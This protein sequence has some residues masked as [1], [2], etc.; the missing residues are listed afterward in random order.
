MTHSLKTY[1]F[2]QN[3]TEAGGEIYLVGGGVRDQ[4]LGRQTKDIDIIIRLIPIPDLKKILKKCGHFNQVGKAFGVIKF[5]PNE[6]RELEID[7]ALPRTEISTGTGHKDFLVQSDPSLEISQ[8]LKRRDF[9]INA[10]AINLETDEIIDLSNGKKDLKNKLIRT[11]FENSFVEDPLRMLRAIQFAARFD[12]NIAPETLEEMKTH[13][14]LISTVS[15][16]RIIIEINKLFD[17]VKP[18]VGFGLMRETKLLPL[19]FPDIDK[20][21]GVSQ[22]KKENE[23]VYDHTMRVLDAMRVEEDLEKPGDLDLMFAALFH[24]SGKPKTRREDEEGKISFYNHHLISAGIAG[25]WL[26]EHKVTTI[27]VNKRKVC[28]LIKHHMFETVHFKDNDKALRRFINK[29]KKEY[30]F[31][32]LDLRLADKK[33]GRFPKKTYG[34]LKLREQIREQINRKA[35]FSPKDLALNGHDIM[36]LGHKP[37][38]SIG[39]IQRFLMEKVLDHPELNTKEELTKLIEENKD[40]FYDNKTK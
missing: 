26:K 16:E 40:T 9:T 32:L 31:D 38:P 22:P 24:D 36:A 13:A 12:F 23:D 25:R 5:Y 6:D 19:V 18:S 11:V 14:A 3:V 10:M 29:A 39:I 34:I 33:G 15:P 2:F 35:P 17:A 20:M 27:G 7:I 21:I 37:G 30:I 8:D 1:S 4:M 28:H